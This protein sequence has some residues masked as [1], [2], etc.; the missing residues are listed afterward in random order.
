[1][2]EPAPRATM[3]GGRATPPR[4]GRAGSMRHYNVRPGTASMQRKFVQKYCGRVT[5]GRACGDDAHHCEP[6][7][8]LYS[9]PR[10]R[11]GSGVRRCMSNPH[12]TSLVEQSPLDKGLK[13][14]SPVRSAYEREGCAGVQV[15][16]TR[17]PRT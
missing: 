16:S 7:H 1:V 6:R 13:D 15:P 11:P 3:P 17:Q 8:A 12:P 2:E 5:S 14:P 9:I 10:W 4:L